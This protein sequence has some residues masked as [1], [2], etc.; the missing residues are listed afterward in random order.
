MLYKVDVGF[1]SIKMTSPGVCLMFT[2]KN[3]YLD[4]V[5]HRK[6]D[7]GG[8]KSSSAKKKQTMSS[9]SCENKNSLTHTTLPT[10]A[11]QFQL[12]NFHQDLRLIRAR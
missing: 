12:P 1:W 10:I 9:L 8:E 4:C 11:Y 2:E 7:K 3:C 6:V 5:Q